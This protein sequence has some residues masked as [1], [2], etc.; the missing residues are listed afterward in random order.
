[1]DEIEVDTRLG[2]KLAATLYKTSSRNQLL[3]IASA[4]GVKQQ[5]YRKFAEYIS[6]NGITVIT[7]DYSGIGQSLK[8][9]IQTVKAAAA[10]WGRNDLEA[11]LQYA[12]ENYPAATLC[13]LGHS[14]GVQ[15]IGL[16]KSSASAH[17]MVLVA[18]QSGFWKWWKGTNRIKMWLNWYLLF[19]G[20]T[21]LFGYMPTKKISGM[22]NLPKHVAQQW[23]RWCRKANYLFDDIPADQL[24]FDKIAARIVAISIENDFYAPSESVDWLIEKYSNAA[25]RKVHLDPNDF[26]VSSIGHFGIFREQFAASIWKK[27]L[28]EL[29][30]TNE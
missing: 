13:V 22:E 16:A 8:Q 19:P 21:S 26:Q 10:D 14:I 11:V 3:I 23:S 29:Q 4:T 25:V 24:H 5:F 30:D 27:L 9:P 15:L 1:M 28:S 7:F 20:L 6:A 18:A 12:K 2:Y 17:K